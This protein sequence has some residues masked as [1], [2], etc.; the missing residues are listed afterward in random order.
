[1]KNKQVHKV[2]M[3]L[4][5][6]AKSKDICNEWYQYLLQAS[7]VDQLAEM[8]I[9]GLDFCLENN[10]P[11]NK[12]IEK[13]FKGKMEHKGIYLNDQG[14][15]SGKR[16]VVLLGN[17]CCTA[18]LKGYD[19]SS[20]YIKNTSTLALTVA[21]NAF[22]SITVHDK[23]SVNILATGEAKVCVYNYGGNVH[24]EENSTATVKIINK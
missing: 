9:G 5:E 3:E 21:D 22:A 7:S 18:N 11:S 8:Y 16:R 19:A 6:E 20:I 13:H 10:F 15:V 23:G 1:M 14:N 4:A 12:F 2:A 17:S 24:V